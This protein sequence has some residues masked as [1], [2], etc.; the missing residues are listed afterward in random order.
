M[1][2]S[3]ELI[4]TSKFISVCV[5]IA[6]IPVLLTFKY[7]SDLNNGAIVSLRN[8]YQMPNLEINCKWTDQKNY[9]ECFNK[10]FLKF[11][12]TNTSYEAILAFELLVSINK[13]DIVKQTTNLGKIKSKLDFLESL[14]S[15]FE[16][17]MSKKMRRDQADFLNKSLTYLKRSEPIKIF[18]ESKKYFKFLD[19]EISNQENKVQI[20]RLR[21]IKNRYSNMKS[22]ILD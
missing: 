10:D 14:I 9:N 6:L 8:K 2:N 11:I 20:N 16:I 3:Y 1:K 4:S 7:V 5:L 22:K 18:H 15:F 13:H 17:N 21:I 12:R 19:D